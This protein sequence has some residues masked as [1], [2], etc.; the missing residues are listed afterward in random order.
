MV[1]LFP[2]VT[3]SACELFLFI[4]K[5]SDR[6]AP[7]TAHFQVPTQCNSLP[8][9]YSTLPQVQLLKSNIDSVNIYNKIIHRLL[10]YYYSPSYEFK[11]NCVVA[12]VHVLETKKY[13]LTNIWIIFPKS[14][15][16]PQPGHCLPRADRSLSHLSHALLSVTE[17][18]IG[19]SL[20]THVSIRELFLSERQERDH[21]KTV[22]HG[23]LLS[24]N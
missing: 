5:C 22:S 13:I 17:K 8:Y 16:Q 15:C 6:V 19:W 21:S 12:T 1:R 7:R 24:I 3:R 23:P 10:F 18:R 14:E 11:K 4:I 9:I 2:L 20:E